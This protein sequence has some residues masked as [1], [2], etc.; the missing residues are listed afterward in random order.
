MPFPTKK[1]NGKMMEDCIMKKVVFALAALALLASCNKELETPG[2]PAPETTVAKAPVK[3][4][5]DVA[6][7]GD[8]AATKAV[9]QGWETNDCIYIWFNDVFVDK[10]ATSQEIRN[11]DLRLRYDGTKW[12]DEYQVEGLADALAA[13]AGGTSE[14]YE[15][16]NGNG[17]YDAGVDVLKSAYKGSVYA[18]WVS[19]N[20]LMDAS[21]GWTTDVSHPVDGHNYL[22]LHPACFIRPANTSPMVLTSGFTASSGYHGGGI[23]Y[24]YYADS[25]TLTLVSATNESQQ[26]QLTWKFYTNFQI[27]VTGLEPGHVYS[28]K[29]PLFGSNDMYVV[30]NGNRMCLTRM[31]NPGSEAANFGLEEYAKADSGGEAV[32]FGQGMEITS[33]TDFAFTLKDVTAGKTYTCTK[34]GKTLACSDTKL[35]AIK[36]KFYDFNHWTVAGAFNSWGADPI[37]MQRVSAPDYSQD[38]RNGNWEADIIGY[39]TGQQFKLYFNNDWQEGVAGMKYGWTSYGLGDWG[40]NQNYLS[41]ESNN[42]NIV[43]DGGDGDY[44]LF[45]SY[46]SHWFVITQI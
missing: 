21:G 37:V 27:T 38:P 44:H 19:G 33:A 20:N 25:N 11:C 36:L 34:T 40:N 7:P 46:P 17:V 5:F 22:F 14:Y 2:S 31:I 41:G 3:I 35:A 26:V 45:F 6:S 18:I 23:D 30:D 10:N 12:N 1:M 28:L 43:I 29:S 8:D 9:K 13:K 32:F 39:K 16:T 24:L 15:D 42:I 4:C